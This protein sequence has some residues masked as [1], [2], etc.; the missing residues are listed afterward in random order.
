M[1][2]QLI[3]AFK[4]VPEEQVESMVRV[5]FG[6]ELLNIITSEQS[7]ADR[8]VRIDQIRSNP[9]VRHLSAKNRESI[10]KLCTD[11]EVL[12]TDE[13][14]EDDDQIDVTSPGD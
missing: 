6:N 13:E 14:F 12:I 9:L 1:N 3:E 7:E 11:A 5:Y 8:K 10:L 2:A 4:R